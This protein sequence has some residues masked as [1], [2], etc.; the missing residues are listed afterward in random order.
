MF[1]KALIEKKYKEIIAYL[2]EKHFECCILYIVQHH[3]TFM[4][5]D[6]NKEVLL[7]SYKQIN[8]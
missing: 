5:K 3:Q 2:R 6:Q 7:H 4:N 1:Y 8:V